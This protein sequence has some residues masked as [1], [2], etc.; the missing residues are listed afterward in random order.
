MVD[1]TTAAAVIETGYRTGAFGSNVTGRM[2]KGGPDQIIREIEAAE[3]WCECDGPLVC[4]RAWPDCSSVITAI[5][6]CNRALRH[7]NVTIRR[8][9]LLSLRPRSP[10]ILAYSCQR[11]WHQLTILRRYS[12][13]VLVTPLHIENRCKN[14]AKNLR[15]ARYSSASSADRR[16]CHRRHRTIE[17][18]SLSP[19]DWQMH[20]WGMLDCSSS[21]LH[22]AKSS[23][24]LYTLFC[25]QVIAVDM[26]ISIFAYPN[27]RPK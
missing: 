25:S 27:K 8:H 18:M 3:S 9:P 5:K 14:V 13:D 23:Y 21:R 10:G 1:W 11:K 26:S 19:I 24:T 4:L 20:K 16:Q 12:S 22:F 2:I 15:Q 17:Y 7:I 6:C